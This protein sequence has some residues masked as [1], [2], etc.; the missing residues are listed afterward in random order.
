M[1]ASIKASI[2]AAIKAL[3]NV[4]PSLATDNRLH[5]SFASLLLALLVVGSN[6]R[7]PFSRN[8]QQASCFSRQHKLRKLSS[9]NLLLQDRTLELKHAAVKKQ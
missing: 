4:P 3:T 5:A 1:K 2:K 8:G 9:S 6:E 7:T